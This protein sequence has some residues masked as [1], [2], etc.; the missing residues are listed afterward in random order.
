CLVLYSHMREE[1]VSLDA[2]I[3]VVAWTL[4]SRAI[5]LSPRGEG[6]RQRERE[7]EGR[8]EE[9]EKAINRQRVLLQHLQPF[10]SSSSSLI[11]QASVCAAGDSAA[12]QR[13]SCFGDDVVVVA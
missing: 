12:Y 5:F 2:I 9:M 11:S 3:S 10:P 13:N 1:K 8:I 6:Q 4:R 7:R